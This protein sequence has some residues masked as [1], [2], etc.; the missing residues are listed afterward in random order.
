MKRLY[1]STK[2][3]KISGVC[4]GI[5]EYLKI[6]PII[7]RIVFILGV[8]ATGIFPLV[9]AYFLAAWLL[10]EAPKRKIVSDQ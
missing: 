8:F 10:P 5:G 1:K 7:V 2:D 4:G 6:D 9:V 3:K